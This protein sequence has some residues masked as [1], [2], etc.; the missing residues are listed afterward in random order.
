[1]KFYNFINESNQPISIDD[2]KKSF[3]NDCKEWFKNNSI[4]DLLYRGIKDDSLEIFKGKV[5][6]NRKPLDST[7]NLHDFY[8]AAFIHK[9]K[10]LLRS[11]SLF[12]SLVKS[13]ANSYGKIYVIF[14]IGNYDLYWSDNVKD[15]FI[16]NR[17][18]YK[19][20]N[21]IDYAKTKDKIE[22]TIFYKKQPDDRWN[23]LYQYLD[24]SID[25]NIKWWIDKKDLENKLNVIY[26]Q[27]KNY[28]LSHEVSTYKK[29]KNV[30]SLNEIMLHCKNYYAISYNIYEDIKNEFS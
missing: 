7:K 18:R 9:F 26:N 27:N 2:F 1:M 16:Y 29:T 24:S 19:I 15:Q 4:D 21:M 6:K 14:P 22:L 8:N 3:K 13:V 5:L 30:T 25:K 23:K 20:F 28:I 11:Q 12:C 17:E 10:I